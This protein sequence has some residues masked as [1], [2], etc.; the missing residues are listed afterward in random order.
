MYTI[1]VDDRQLIVDSMLRIL[2]R[3]DPEGNH[4]GTTEP[5][6]ALEMAREEP[7]DVAFLD[8]EMPGMNGLTLAK[9]L[10]AQ[11]PL[12][13]IIFITGYQEYALDA[14]SVYATGFLLKPVTEKS[15]REALNHLRYRPQE[16][17]GQELSIHCFGNFEVF[18]RGKPLHFSR[19]KSKELFAYLIDRQGAK[20]ESDAIIGNLW[21][22]MAASESLKGQ[23]R[24][25]I[26]DLISTLR[27]AGATN[28]ILR[29]RSGISVD[30]AKLNCD[31][32]RFLAGDPYAL[33]LYHGEYMTQYEFAEETRANLMRRL[34]RL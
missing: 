1:C 16:K 2:S 13:N 28:V 31:Y 15:V 9:Q 34:Y 25:I 27:D 12:I 4:R 26:A 19:S 6:Q 18:Y 22:E 3:V 14:F 32:Y 20:C 7:V 21:P 29:D 17:S 24:V 5:Q 10:Q 11:N 23:L 8:M 33:H 30:T